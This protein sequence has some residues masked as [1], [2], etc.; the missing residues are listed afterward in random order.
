MDTEE[1]IIITKIEIIILDIIMKTN[2][3]KKT[4]IIK[5]IEIIDFKIITNFKI[6]KIIITIIM[7][8]IIKIEEIMGKMVSLEILTINFKKTDLITI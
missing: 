6:I 2:I 3:I 4:E 5:K 1:M 8:I 7:V